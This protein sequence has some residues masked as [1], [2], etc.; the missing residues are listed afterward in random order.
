MDLGKFDTQRNAT[1][2]VNMELKHPGTGQV[3]KQD[4]TGVPITINLTGRDAADYQQLAHKVQNKKLDKAGRSGRLKVTA[5]EIED[6]ELALLVLST[7]GW[8]GITIEG[9]AIEY[10]PEAAKQLYLRFPWIREQASEFVADRSNFL[11]NS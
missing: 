3:L 9:V 7:K 1:Q 5:E 11:G 2:G 10:S 6:D 4:G 8:A